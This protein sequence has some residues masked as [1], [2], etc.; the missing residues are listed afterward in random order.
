MSITLRISLVIALGV[1]MFGWTKGLFHIPPLP[2]KCMTL[3]EY[4]ELKPDAPRT[5]CVVI[6]LANKE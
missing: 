5:N 3:T 4:R 2:S 6:Q 1:L